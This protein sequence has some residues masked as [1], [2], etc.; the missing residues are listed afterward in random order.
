MKGSSHLSLPDHVSL[1][2]RHHLF[3]LHLRLR[4][5]VFLFEH[6]RLEALAETTAL[7]VSGWS[8]ALTSCAAYACG[9]ESGGSCPSLCWVGWIPPSEKSV[10]WQNVYS[11]FTD[12]QYLVAFLRL[13]S[14]W[15]TLKCYP[16]WPRAPPC[17]LNPGFQRGDLL[18]CKIHQ[19]I[20]VRHDTWDACKPEHFFT[21]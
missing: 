15:G 6:T 12:P 11:G 7:H 3:T 18:G 8:V 4:F 21:C 13:H 14:H 5:S 2:I 16:C 9:E 1:L 10:Q 19:K 17:A 20:I